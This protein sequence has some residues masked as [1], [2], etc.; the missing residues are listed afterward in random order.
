MKDTIPKE[1]V[2]CL[3]CKHLHTKLHCMEILETKKML[4][5]QGYFDRITKTFEI[6]YQNLTNLVGK[7][8]T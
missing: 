4:G 5:I 8:F 2:T 6:L 1:I 7:G 3:V